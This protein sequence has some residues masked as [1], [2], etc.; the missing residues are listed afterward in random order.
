MC[1]QESSQVGWVSGDMVAEGLGILD[2]IL[3]PT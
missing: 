1:V 3:K 2:G